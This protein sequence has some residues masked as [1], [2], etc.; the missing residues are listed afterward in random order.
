M[1]VHGL[2]P[3]GDEYFALDRTGRP[4]VEACNIFSDCLAAVGFAE[5]SRAQRRECARD[6][7]RRP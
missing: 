2:N 7:A 3:E 1:K 4:P 6:R 5:H